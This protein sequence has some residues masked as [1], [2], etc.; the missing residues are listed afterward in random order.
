MLRFFD[1]G[2]A[3]ARRPSLLYFLRMVITYHGAEFFKVSL[4]ETVIA[5][6]PISKRSKLKGPRFGANLALVT[7]RHEDMDGADAVAFGE[8]TPF[9]IDGPGEYEIGGLTV[10]GFPSVSRYG[11][12]KRGNAIY[13]VSLEGM[14]LLFL[15]A[16]AEKELQPEAREALENIDVLFVPIGGDGVLSPA[17]A[18]DCA[19]ALEP[20]LV[21]PM[22]YGS[23][24]K[25]GALAAF[26]KEWGENPAPAEKLTLKKKD[27]EGKEGEVAVLAAE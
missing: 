12:K 10:R 16:L 11:G 27:L 9:V 17:E 13:L 19:V 24:G 3:V 2:R 18:H 7:L 1:R 25:A 4:G 14:R 8:K 21:I 26:L 6:N 15:G 20:R 22:H 5:L 23:V